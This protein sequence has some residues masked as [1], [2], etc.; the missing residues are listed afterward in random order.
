MTIVLQ[1]VVNIPNEI[2]A[3]LSFYINPKKY[4]NLTDNLHLFMYLII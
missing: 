2:S 4:G 3:V 1:N